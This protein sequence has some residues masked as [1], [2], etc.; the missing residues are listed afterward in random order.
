MAQNVTSIEL[1]DG[2]KVFYSMTGQQLFAHTAYRLGWIP[3]NLISEIPSND[4]NLLACFQFGRW[5]GDKPYALD[6]SK[7]INPQLRIKWNLAAVNAVGAT[8]FVTGTGLFSAIADVMEGAEI[9]GALITAK[10]HYLFTTAASGTEYIDLPTDQRLKAIMIRSQKAATGF[11]AGVS[12][13]KLTADQDKFVPINARTTDFCRLMT[14]FAPPFHYKHHFFGKNGD[15]IYPV[16]KTEEVISLLSEQTDMVGG[17]YDYG[18]GDGALVL[19]HAGSA[20]TS[21]TDVWAIVEG[22]MPY[23]CVYMPQGEWDDPSTWLDAT[24]FRNLRLELAM[25]SASANASVVLEQE[26]IY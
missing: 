19:Y 22:F 17:Y 21:N 11:L 3:Y 2:S 23:H 9:P 1:I 6:P 25:D 24:S 8:G 14:L 18:I 26:Y 7:L 4:Q 5:F 15:T 20:E 10:Q 12:N 13:V 16:L